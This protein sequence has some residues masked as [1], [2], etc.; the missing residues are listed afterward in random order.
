[1]FFAYLSPMAG[2]AELLKQILGM[3]GTGGLS[4]ASAVNPYAAAANAVPQLIQGG[5]GIAQAIK[6]AKLAKSTTRPWM[7]APAAQT[8][9]LFNARN[10]AAGQAPGLNTAIQQ[11][12]Q[13]QAG[14][15]SAIQNSGGGGAERLAALAMLDQ[16]AGDQALD[17]GA[18]QENWQA[19]QALNL[20]NQLMQMAETQ[21]R[22]FMYNK[23]EPY[24]NIMQASKEQTDAGI[25]NIHG[26]AT[27][28]G[29]TFASAITKGAKADV[30]ALVD[31]AAKTP[32]AMTPGTGPVESVVEADPSKDYLAL[33]GIN[34]P[35]KPAPNGPVESVVEADPSKDY[36]ALLGIND[37]LKPAPNGPAE[38]IATNPLTKSPAPKINTSGPGEPIPFMGSVEPSDNEMPALKRDLKTG[39]FDPKVYDPRT[40][41]VLPKN[42]P[43]SIAKANPNARIYGVVPKPTFNPNQGMESYDF[44]NLS[45]SEIYSPDGNGP[46]PI[47]YD[48]KTG[49]TSPVAAPPKYNPQAALPEGPFPIGYDKNGK[50]GQ[51][52][53]SSANP[54]LLG[55]QAVFNNL[56]KQLGLM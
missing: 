29:G 2:E 25:Q 44:N 55:G 34:D 17:L 15:T 50:I 42:S 21:Q 32:D 5:I 38:T 49:V 41:K 43:N 26:A 8:E 40:G 46:F 53:G 48:P 39:N 35:L 14:S 51:A 10:M 30:N 13:S 12:A 4:A 54:K 18:M 11:L 3:A 47:G 7:K 52:L 24:R 36:L 27:G 9:A 22:Q 23:D 37:P 45:S 1:M 16:N 31:P 19:Q 56:M 6:G 33:L 28:L 20:Q